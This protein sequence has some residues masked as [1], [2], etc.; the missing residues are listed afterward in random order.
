MISIMLFFLGFGFM[1]YLLLLQPSTCV[2]CTLQS[3]FNG[4]KC[5]RYGICIQSTHPAHIKIHKKPHPSESVEQNVYIIIWVRVH[6]NLQ[7]YNKNIQCHCISFTSILLPLRCLH[8][9]K[10][11][12]SPSL[13]EHCRTRCAFP[14]PEEV[15]RKVLRPT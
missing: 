6:L 8:S 13:C 15:K 3:A 12:G 10:K 9:E 2:I 14:K 5:S 7:P 1:C 11:Y 4:K